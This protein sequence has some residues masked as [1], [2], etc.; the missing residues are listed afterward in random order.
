MDR[1]R[2]TWLGEFKSVIFLALGI[3]G[4]FQIPNMMPFLVFLFIVLFGMIALFRLG[5]VYILKKEENKVNNIIAGAINLFFV[6]WS[7]K[8]LL[9]YSVDNYREFADNVFVIISVWIALLVVWGVYEGIKLLIQKNIIG[10]IV[11]VEAIL[12]G[13]LWFFFYRVTLAIKED[14]ENDKVIFNFGVFCISLALISFFN[15]K[16]VKFLVTKYKA[17]K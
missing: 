11:L 9:N 3:I 14:I 8:E 17:E 16:V 6:G 2:S 10:N 5:E 13:L 1:I 12:S 15:S 4:V 7:V